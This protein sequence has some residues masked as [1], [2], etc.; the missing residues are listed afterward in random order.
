MHRLALLA[1]VLTA[2]QV[3]ASDVPPIPINTDAYRH[4]HLWPLQRIGARGY[5]HSTYDRSGGNEGGKVHR[6][7]E[8]RDVRGWSAGNRAEAGDASGWDRCE[9]RQE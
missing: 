8:K 6:R 1:I 9:L 4:W 7:S 2:T 5:M 3:L